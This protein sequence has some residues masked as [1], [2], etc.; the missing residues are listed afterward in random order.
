MLEFSSGK[1]LA[2]SDSDLRRAS[3]SR[4]TAAS[5]GTERLIG[6]DPLSSEH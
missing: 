1:I 5:L 3:M 2:V 6:Q 4:G